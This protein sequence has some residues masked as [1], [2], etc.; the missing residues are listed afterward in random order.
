MLRRLLRRIALIA[1]LL[2]AGGGVAVAETTVAET[3]VVDATGAEVTVGDTGRIVSIGGAVTEVVFAL[4]FADNVV[5][6]D[7]TSQYPHAVAEKPDVGYMRRLSAE[8]ILGLAPSV[9]LAVEDA[10]PETALNQ[11]R[12]SGVPVVLVP[13][14]PSYDGVLRKI[15]LIAAALGIEEKGRAVTASLRADFKRLSDAVGGVGERPKVLFLL[16]IGQGGA[17]LAG[18]RKTSADGI[19][20]LAGG[21]NAVD[22]FEG[23]KPLSPEAAVLAAPDVLLVTRRTLDL[24]G[25]RAG[26]LGRPE[27]SLTPAAQRGRVVAIDGLLLL[28]FGPRTGQAVRTLAAELHP[29]L[30]LPSAGSR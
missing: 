8:P 6:V 27:I 22:A 18:G 12:E 16:S 10:G 1:L 25:G 11:L 21:I 24:L 30:V 3:T 20:R 26:L 4:G 28:G 19:I 29:D 17:P 9:V 15:G 13:D 2:P 23:F 5:A 7:S 14:D